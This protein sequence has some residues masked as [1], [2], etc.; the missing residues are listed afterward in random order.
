[1]GA[2]ERVNVF[3]VELPVSVTVHGP[4]PEVAQ[5]YLAVAGFPSDGMGGGGVKCHCQECGNLGDGAEHFRDQL[6]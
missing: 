6:T 5:D 3:N 2:D 1:M 4:G